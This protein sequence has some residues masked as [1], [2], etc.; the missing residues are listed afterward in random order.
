MISG[1]IHAPHFN[2]INEKIAIRHLYA[3]ALAMFWRRYPGLFSTVGKMADQENG[4]R[5]TDG[6]TLFK[7]YLNGHPQEL[8]DYL[9]LFLP[10]ELYQRFDCENFGW[11][12]GLISEE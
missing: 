3:S 6:F 12:D 8:R 1:K 9:K 11:T 10:E 7:E 4:Y 2:I 5:G